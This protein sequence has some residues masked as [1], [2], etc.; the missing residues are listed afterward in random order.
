MKKYI[1]ILIFFIGAF[2]TAC[3]QESDNLGENDQSEQKGNTE[4]TIDGE[5][6]SDANENNEDGTKKNEGEQAEETNKHI[7]KI[8]EETGLHVVDN[9]ESKLVY[10]NKQRQ[11]PV[12]YVPPNLTV[13]DVPHY[14]SEGDPKRQLQ[15]VAA[16]ALEDLFATAKNNQ[17]GLIAVSGYRSY[18]RQ[19]QIYEYNVETKGKAHADKYSAIPGTSEHQ[20]GLSMDVAS[21]TETSATLLEQTFSQT[22][23]GTWLADHAHDFGFIIRYPKG[24]SNI[25][26]YSYEPWHIRFVGKEVAETIYQKGITLEEHFGYDY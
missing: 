3:Q 5:E 19:K 6:S 15:K 23:A 7:A 16:D 4:Q 1:V 20:T 24:K 14:A 18:E 22:D 8:E 12:G 10:V 21:A 17:V 13:P 2:L 9:P 26:G 25:T 11:L